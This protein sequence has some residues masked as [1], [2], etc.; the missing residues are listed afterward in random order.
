MSIEHITFSNS[1]VV[2]LPSR[3]VVLQSHWLSGLSFIL[4]I[5]SVYKLFSTELYCAD[6]LL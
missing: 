1:F 6:E 5:L 2:A 4:S 3:S